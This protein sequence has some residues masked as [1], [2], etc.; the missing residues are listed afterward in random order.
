MKRPILP[1]F[2]LSLGYT[3]FYLSFV[4]LIPLFVLL[5]QPVG[6]GW[7][8]FWKA[9]TSRRALSAYGVSF[10]TALVAASINFVVGL[11]TTWVLVRYRFPGRKLLDALVDF[12]FALPTAVA[13]VCFAVLYSPAGWLGQV[14]EPAGIHVVNTTTGITLAL[15]FIGLPFVVR[16][17]QPVLADLEKE[18]EES[19]HSL[20]ADRWQTFARVVFPALFPSL[21]TGFTLAFSRGVGEYGSVIF[22]AGNLPFKTE[23]APLIIMAKLDQFDYPGA[24][25][26]AAVLLLFSFVLLLLLNT[27]QTWANKEPR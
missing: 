8:A 11:I 27:V 4:V 6:L 1:G 20:G 16:T 10:S 26:V 21:V 5:V 25:S 18:M 9:A 3:V 13:G 17:L 2:G 23:I 15:V 24:A 22:I 7:E 19:A 14:L 12:P